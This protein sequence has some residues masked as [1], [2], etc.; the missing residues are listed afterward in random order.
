MHWT[1]FRSIKDIGVFRF[2]VLLC[3]TALCSAIN[4]PAIPPEPGFH[5]TD[6]MEITFSTK[7]DSD[8]SAQR[9]CARSKK[10]HYTSE[11]LMC[12]VESSGWKVSSK[13]RQQMGS[14]FRRRMTFIFSMKNSIMG[15]FIVFEQGN[16]SKETKKN[17]NRTKTNSNDSNQSNPCK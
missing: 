1:I 13:F 7:Y 12:V 3:P 6:W 4:Y 5:S 8:W 17:T 10:N 15:D 11:L 16:G 2:A 9:N 14:M